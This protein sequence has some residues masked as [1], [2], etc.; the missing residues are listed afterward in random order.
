M[1]V[2]NHKFLVWAYDN[3]IPKIFVELEIGLFLEN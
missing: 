2:K 3:I 1:N